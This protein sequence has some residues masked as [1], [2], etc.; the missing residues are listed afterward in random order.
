MVTFIPVILVGCSSHAA[1][2]PACW[3]GSYSTNRM[4]IIDPIFDFLSQ[5]PQKKAQKGCFKE[6]S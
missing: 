2:I 5:L 4:R 1:L 3:G 6:G